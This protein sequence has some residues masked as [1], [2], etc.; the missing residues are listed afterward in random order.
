MHFLKIP[1]KIVKIIIKS[2]S[3]CFPLQNIILLESNPDYADNT[4]PVYLELCRRREFDK[5]RLIW[6][7]YGNPV[8]IPAEAAS[9]D[10]V[11]RRDG[12]IP[13]NSWRFRWYQM[14]AKV[15]VS[16]NRYFKKQDP[17]QISLFLNHGTP[18]KRLGGIYE[19]GPSVGFLS[20]QTK[21][22]DQIICYED[23]ASPSQLVHLGYPRCDY[24][25]TTNSTLIRK[26]LNLEDS[27]LFFIWLPTFRK[28]WAGRED[29]CNSSF[30]RFGM[31]LIHSEA[32]LEDLNIFLQEQNSHIFLKPHPAQDVSGLVSKSLSH[33]HVINDRYLA[34]INL[35]LY[36]MI[37]ASAALI[38]DY[39][40]VFF[41]YLLLDRPIVTTTD[42]IEE[43]KEGRGFISNMET[44][45][46]KATV[47]AYDLD[48]LKE[49]IISVLRGQ[50]RK[51]AGRKEIRDLVNLFQD[52]KSC[53]RT[54][55]FLLDQLKVSSN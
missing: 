18:A 11:H 33:I 9:M 5:Y 27:S 15:Q 20:S 40:S 41:D 38:T 7:T 1:K 49:F 25:Y 10:N 8:L 2:I 47:R 30:D 28:H 48:S 24:F 31:P 6:V 55:D 17:R 35:Q 46:E 19:P 45:L 29:V 22:V 42:D 21:L 39:S 14:R 54:A 53:Q 37:A 36:Q 12:Q 13:G 32:Q 44:M 23:N 43:W 3:R 16:C 4:Y 51:K 52:G 34:E 50:D 26:I